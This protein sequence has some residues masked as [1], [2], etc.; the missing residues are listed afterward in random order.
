MRI[1]LMTLVLLISMANQSLAKYVKDE[2]LRNDIFFKG[3]LITE[4]RN[5]SNDMLTKY[6]FYKGTFYTCKIRFLTNYNRT[7]VVCYDEDVSD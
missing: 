7:W 5:E 4:W 6:I 2:E 3:S 1:L